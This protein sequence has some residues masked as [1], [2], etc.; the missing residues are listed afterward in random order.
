MNCDTCDTFACSGNTLPYGN[1]YAPN[2]QDCY[3]QWQDWCRDG[4]PNVAVLPNVDSCH[5]WD[6]SWTKEGAFCPPDKGGSTDGGYCCARTSDGGLQWGGEYKN[7]GDCTVL[8]PPSVL[9]IL[10]SPLGP[11]DSCP[12]I[13]QDDTNAGQQY[14]HGKCFGKRLCS[15][16]HGNLNDYACGAPGDND[17]KDRF[18][19]AAG[20]SQ[21][22]DSFDT[23]GVTTMQSSNPARVEPAIFRSRDRT[24]GSEG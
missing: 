24:L 1:T 8:R 2:N 3:R 17:M 20:F 10:P 6:C 9:E 7:A 22:L 15:T 11:Y 5:Y 21:H 16:T 19:L 18:K 4:N 14:C 13:W 12:R 23:S